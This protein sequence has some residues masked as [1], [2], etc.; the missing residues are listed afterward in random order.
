MKLIFKDDTK[1]TFLVVG[2]PLP[3]L[4]QLSNFLQ[5]TETKM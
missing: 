1:D 3:R 5:E 2:D 4:K